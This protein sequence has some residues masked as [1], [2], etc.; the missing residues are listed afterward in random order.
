[1]D[2]T[3]SDPN[4]LGR[5]SVPILELNGDPDNFGFTPSLQEMDAGY[6]DGESSTL[7]SSSMQ[8]KPP[9]QVSPGPRRLV[10]IA[11]TGG[12]ASS[13]S[14]TGGPACRRSKLERRGH[15]KSRNGCHNCKRRRIK[16]GSRLLCLSR[17][18]MLTSLRSV[19]KR[20]L[21]VATARKPA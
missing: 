3:I 14:S 21:R 9:T 11:P 18:P 2:T 12:K 4:F 8:V 1:M 10:P 7:P 17:D 16:V 6:L 5:L 19:K 20:D 13:S 15:A